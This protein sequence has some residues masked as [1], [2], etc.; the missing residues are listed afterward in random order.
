MHTLTTKSGHKIELFNSIHELPMKRSHAFTKYLGMDADIGSDMNAVAKHYEK[1]F[2]FSN[3][4]KE[5]KAEL[6]KE[7]YNLYF[8]WFL[9]LEN[10]NPQYLSFACMV[11]KIDEK[12]YNDLTEE[13]L[14]KVV[15]ALYETGLTAGELGDWMDALKKNLKMNVN[16]A[17]QSDL[18]A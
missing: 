13:G 5:M 10:V 8:F 1:L 6:Q 14:Q 17:F 18:Q 4:P 2:M 12:E 11:S 15:E 16:F 3:N 9:I 7:A